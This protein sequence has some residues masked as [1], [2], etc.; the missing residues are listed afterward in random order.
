[1]P[2]GRTFIALAVPRHTSLSRAELL[3]SQRNN[4]IHRRR[5]TRGKVAREHCDEREEDG[6][7]DEAHGSVGVTR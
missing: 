1:M 6:D 4:G 7:A 5:A 3:V 2:I